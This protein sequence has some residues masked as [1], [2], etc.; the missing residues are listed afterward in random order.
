MAIGCWFAR[1]SP[2]RQEEVLALGT[3]GHYRTAVVALLAVWGLRVSHRTVSDHFTHRCSCD[4]RSLLVGKVADL[5]ERAGLSAEDVGRI[6][7]V[8]LWQGLTKDGTGD[9]TLTDLVGVQLTPPE[10]QEPEWPVVQPAAPCVVKYLKVSKGSKAP[11][12]LGVAVTLPDVQIGY[13]VDGKGTLHATHDEAAIDVALQIVHTVRPDRVILHG[14]NAD[15]PELGK[16]RVSPTFARTTQATVDRAGLFAAQVRAAVGEE[17]KITWLEGNHEAR[18]PNYII[19]NA[20]AAF[21]LRQAGK[22]D[23]WPV[24]SVPSLTRLDEHGITYLPGYPANEAWINDRLR[25]IHGHQVV[26]NG[27]TAHKYLAHERVSTV[28]G[29]IHRREWAER[30]RRTRTGPRTILALSP[31][32][33][34]RTDGAV[35][36]TKG[37]RDLD[38]VPIPSTED[39]QQGLAVFTYEPGDGRFV[40]EQVPIF[41]G[42]AMF[43]GREFRANVTPI[44][45]GVGM[46]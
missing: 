33:L 20:K 31:G 26:S 11:G 5:I 38:G 4:A 43:R 27:S 29:H 18:L 37:G 21:G 44:T 45:P 36:S 10:N 17:C 30:T 46:E 35:P 40:P 15:F 41:D 6:N 3:E 28:F 9:P 42:W 13:Y 32:C 23:S 19:D 1:L 25:V 34:C 24:L 8:N 22:P 2:E 14:D 16:Y 7:R 12:H 39:W